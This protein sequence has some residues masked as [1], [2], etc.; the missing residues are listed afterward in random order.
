MILPVRP[1]ERIM[2]D[3]AASILGLSTRT[4]QNLAIRGM[5]PSAAKLGRSWTFNEVELRRHIN[6]K[7]QETCQN[8][9]TRTSIGVAKI[10]G[11]ISRSTGTVRSKAYAS[12]IDAL[13]SGKPTI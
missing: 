5:I 9:R 1:P 3:R 8:N 6:T 2:I 4:I 7:E 10:G 12:V 11:P 13:R